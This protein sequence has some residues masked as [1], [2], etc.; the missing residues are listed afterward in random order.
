MGRLQRLAQYLG[1]SQKPLR[2]ARFG[3]GVRPEEGTRGSEVRQTN[4]GTRH[5]LQPGGALLTEAEFQAEEKWRT[6][7]GRAKT[8]REGKF[9]FEKNNKEANLKGTLTSLAHRQGD[10]RQAA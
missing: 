7:P 1:G 2:H 9:T 4:R 3:Q 10:S 5:S 6:F 8:P